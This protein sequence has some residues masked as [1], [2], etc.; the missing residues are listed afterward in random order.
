MIVEAAWSCD[1]EAHTFSLAFM[2]MVRDPNEETCTHCGSGPIR[3]HRTTTYR[4]WQRT[5]LGWQAVS[6]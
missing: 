5:P 3:L 2:A 4:R 1:C 6:V